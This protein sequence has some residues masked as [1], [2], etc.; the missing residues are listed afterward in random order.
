M[1]VVDSLIENARKSAQKNEKLQAIHATYK[2]LES[3]TKDI[4][5]SEGDLKNLSAQ[6]EALPKLEEELLRL[7]TQT[8]TTTTEVNA[9]L[10][11]DIYVGHTH[12]C[13]TGGAVSPKS[14][15]PISEDVRVTALCVVTQIKRMEQRSEQL[16]EECD[17]VVEADINQRNQDFVVVNG[18]R[19]AKLY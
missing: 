3:K 7:E 2:A 6:L 12:G 10:L 17:A 1:T 18:A 4:K 5:N 13:R 8:Q 9:R 19:E 11:V 14:T 16:R 15:I